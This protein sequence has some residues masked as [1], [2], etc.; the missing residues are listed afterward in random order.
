MG[1]IEE[2]NLFTYI[3]QI[4]TKNRK[5]PYDKKIANAYILTL[6]LSMNKNYLSIINKIN[7]YLYI[8]PDETI[9]EYYM[10]EIPVGKVYSKFIKKREKSDIFKN[11]VEKIKKIYTEMSMREC[12]MLI[13]SMMKKKEKM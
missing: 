13:S 6:F 7:K 5:Y 2:P 3:K 11:R 10:K 12:E 1:N 4:Q 8:L 9:Y